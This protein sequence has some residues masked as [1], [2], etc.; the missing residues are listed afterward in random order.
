VTE[1]P[2]ILF[3]ENLPVSTG[4]RFVRDFLVANAVVLVLSL[5]FSPSPSLPRSVGLLSLLGGAGLLI[6]GGATD[7]SESVSSVKVRQALRPAREYS[8][9]EHRKAQ[10][11]ALRYVMLGAVMMGESILFSL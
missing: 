7:L 10:R 4:A 9:T 6:L 11:M 5:V 8:S 1:G 2:R 3:W